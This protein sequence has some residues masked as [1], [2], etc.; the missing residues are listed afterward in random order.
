MSEAIYTHL[1][2]TYVAAQPVFIYF[3]SCKLNLIA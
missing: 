1:N 2:T 3:L